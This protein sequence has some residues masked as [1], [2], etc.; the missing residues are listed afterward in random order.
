[1]DGATGIFFPAVLFSAFEARFSTTQHTLDK[2]PPG[3]NMAARFDPSR[4]R[5]SVPQLSDVV[6]KRVPQSDADALWQAFSSGSDRIGHFIDVGFYNREMVDVAIE[7]WDR[8]MMDHQSLCVGIY[9]QGALAGHIR[10]HVYS[11]PDENGR[12]ICL[13]YW[14]AIPV[15]KRG[16]MHQSIPSFLSFAIGKFFYDI[17]YV[18]IVCHPENIA[19]IAVAERLGFKSHETNASRKECLP[20]LRYRLYVNENDWITNPNAPTDNMSMVPV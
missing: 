12:G 18:E 19:S 3:L 9:V 8:Y 11:R 14:L 4:L 6:L 5:I 2:H 13:E 16:I 15:Q 7:R 1:M 17:S 20:R 10:S